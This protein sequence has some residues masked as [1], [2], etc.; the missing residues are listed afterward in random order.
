MRRLLCHI[1]LALLPAGWLLSASPALAAP[2]GVKDEAGLFSA[3]A[4]R[5][6][7]EKIQT[8]H[9]RARQDL[10]IETIA[11][12]PADKTRQLK[13]DRALFFASWAQ[14][15]AEEAGVNGAY[16]LICAEPRH[17]QVYVSP[18]TRTAFPDKDRDQLRKALS[19]KLGRKAY[20]D[21]LL[22]TVDFARDRLDPSHAAAARAGWWWV[23]WV[24]V[25]IVGVWLVVGLIRSV[26]GLGAAASSSG[27]VLTV[28]FGA[29]AGG[30]MRHA[31]LG[32]R[33][34]NKPA[35]VPPAGLMG[36]AEDR[37]IA[38]DEMK[39]V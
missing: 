34:D 4:V 37:V 25:G 20:D 10:L 11:A 9:R 18:D 21:A 26:L 6:A 27:G 38:K 15:R 1:G 12:V 13:S 5:Q 3:D 36:R 17:V 31:L 32:R 24:I 28:L 14:Q 8:L 35:P 19:R 7:E 2:F 29:T 30:W 33:D 22:D 23:L 39:K 16:V